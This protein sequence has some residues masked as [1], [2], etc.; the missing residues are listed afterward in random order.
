MGIRR[1]LHWQSCGLKYVRPLFLQQAFV[2]MNTLYVMC[3]LTPT[4]QY[5]VNKPCIMYSHL[6]TLT[7]L[8]LILQHFSILSSTLGAFPLF[9]TGT[10]IVPHTV[11]FL[12][13]VSQ[14]CGLY[15]VTSPTFRPSPYLYSTT[16]IR[17]VLLSTFVLLHIATRN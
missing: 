16:Y 12:G 6:Y 8:W 14:F 2:S 4:A 13:G 1:L 10:C 3:L 9:D 5:T 7:I 11:Y 15:A 17:H